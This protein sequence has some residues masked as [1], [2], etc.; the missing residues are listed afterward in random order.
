MSLHPASEAK[1]A[2]AVAEQRLT[3]W[4]YLMEIHQPVEWIDEDH[5]A[6]EI[7]MEC[8]VF[9]VD[10]DGEPCERNSVCEFGDQSWHEHTPGRSVCHTRAVLLGVEQ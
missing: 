3:A 6:I 10:E 7:C 5:N 4:A 9:A 8:C 2:R 1:L